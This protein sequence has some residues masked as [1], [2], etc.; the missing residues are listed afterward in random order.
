MS[1]GKNI[2]IPIVR[3]Q[4][5]CV[6]PQVTKI[7]KKSEGNRFFKQHNLSFRNNEDKLKIQ[8]K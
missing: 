3:L 5:G 4:N 6:H 2:T 8:C 7:H 1:I